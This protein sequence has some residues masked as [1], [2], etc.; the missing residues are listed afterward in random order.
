MKALVLG[1]NGFI[2][3]HLVDKLLIEGHDVRV[4][5]RR[6]DLYR[7][8]I[9]SVEY[10]YAD[11]GNRALLAE[12]LGG[13]DTVFHLICT[14]VPKTS[15]DDPVF[16]VISNV[17]ETIN[18]LENCVERGIRKVV[19]LSS[20]GTVYGAPDSLPVTED[21]PTNPECSYG[22]TKLTIE[23]YLALFHLLYGLHYV[24]VRPSN[25][26]G[27]RQNPRG[28]QGAISVFL[29]RIAEDK[30]IEIWGDG[31]VVRDYVFIDD[32]VDGIYRAA[33]QTTISRILNLGSGEGRSLNMIVDVM[34]RT[35][36]KD[37]RVVYTT[38]R[39]FD[40]PKIYLDSRRASE[41]LAWRPATPFEVGIQ[42]SWEF[43]RGIQRAGMP[44]DGA[45]SKHEV[46][47]LHGVQLGH[48]QL[49]RPVDGLAD[50][51][52]QPRHEHDGGYERVDAHQIQL[53]E[54]RPQQP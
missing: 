51:D 2:G 17:V 35:I 37:V 32:L 49:G 39:P 50:Q 11:F 25:P 22:I 29:G 24:V 47:S 8:P 1:G 23:K 18:L 10:V 26:Y 28:I 53:L 48:N 33:T 6:E 42:K 40:V 41:E 5:D 46:D 27:P 38:R 19:F 13:R 9:S 36:R 15:N 7:D 43:I 21:H 4:F 54:D 3:S 20:G 44:G 45:H 52:V 12:A 16:D 31:E 30:P 34:R 14:T